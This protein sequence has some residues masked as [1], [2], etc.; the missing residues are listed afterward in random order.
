MFDKFNTIEAQFERDYDEFA[1]ESETGG[2]V[3]PFVARYNFGA[4]NRHARRRGPQ[5]PRRFRFR[6]W[7]PA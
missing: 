4:D 5:G 7:S 2:P 1:L 6:S 3:F